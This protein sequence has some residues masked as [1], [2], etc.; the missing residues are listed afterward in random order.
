MDVYKALMHVKSQD[1]LKFS[2]DARCLLLD[3]TSGGLFIW[4]DH[5]EF[6]FNWQMA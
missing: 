4:F 2:D 1:V 6:S 3:F 5:D